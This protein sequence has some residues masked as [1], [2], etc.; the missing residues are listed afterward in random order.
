M[1][2]PVD[3]THPSDSE[4]DYEHEINVHEEDEEDWQDAEEQQP[5]EVSEPPNDPIPTQ[6]QQQQQNKNKINEVDL[7]K[8]IKEIQQNVNLTSSDKAKQIQVC[9]YPFLFIFF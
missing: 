9:T 8:K 7:R 6:Q 1:S 4:I 2:Q 5:N 3:I